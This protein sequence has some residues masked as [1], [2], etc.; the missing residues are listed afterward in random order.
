MATFHH[1]GDAM[2][3]R[4]ADGEYVPS[5]RYYNTD[6]YDLPISQ[7]APPSAALKHFKSLQTKEEAQ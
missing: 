7:L 6:C 1:A 3:R 2:M 5:G 4:L